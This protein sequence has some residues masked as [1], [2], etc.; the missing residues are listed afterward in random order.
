MASGLLY[1]VIARAMK[2]LSKYGAEGLIG[3]EARVVSKLSPHDEAQYMVRVCDE[4]WS[5]KSRDDLK[6]DETV[7]VLPVDG[8]TL[9]VSK[10]CVEQSSSQ[11]KKP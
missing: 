11:A 5:A 4:L 6:P 10:I 2:K 9:L 3:V 7:K 8:L 1:W